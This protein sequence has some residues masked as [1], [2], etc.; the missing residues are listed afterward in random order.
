MLRSRL[1]GIFLLLDPRK[2]DPVVRDHTLVC[3]RYETM[4]P[5]SPQ[6][7]DDVRWFI[8]FDVEFDVSDV[9]SVSLHDA[10]ARHVEKGRQVAQI[11]LVNVGNLQVADWP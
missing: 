9:R 11:K 3:F 7:I 1:I 4:M 8:P 5:V 6:G 2:R 10:V